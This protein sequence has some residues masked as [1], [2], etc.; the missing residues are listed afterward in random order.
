MKDYYGREFNKNDIKN[1][2]DIGLIDPKSLDAF[3]DEEIR[4]SV[5]LIKDPHNGDRLFLLAELRQILKANHYCRLEDPL[6]RK[7]ILDQVPDFK[8]AIELEEQA[9]HYNAYILDKHPHFIPLLATY[10]KE[11]LHKDDAEAFLDTKKDEIRANHSE[12]LA[13]FYG[14][15]A[16]F[17]EQEKNDFF[18]LIITN[19]R[20]FV[21]GQIWNLPAKWEIDENNADWQEEQAYHYLTEKGLYTP[22]PHRNVLVADLITDPESACLHSWGLDI[23]HLLLEYHM[24][25][26]LPFTLFTLEENESGF[27]MEKTLRERL[28]PAVTLNPEQGLAA[29]RKAIDAACDP[30]VLKL[31]QACTKYMDH[32]VGKLGI[33]Y[34]YPQEIDNADPILLKKYHAVHEMYSSLQQRY[35]GQTDEQ[36]IAAFK[37]LY[38]DPERQATIAEHRDNMGIR[39]LNVL[40]SIL[41]V[42]IKNAVTYYLTEGYSG[43]WNSRG[44]HFNQSLETILED[45]PKTP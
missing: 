5:V 25:K 27:Y 16:N 21:H 15:I 42:G 2:D 8:A 10:V 13:K 28:E 44:D 6:T 33:S 7:D 3:S 29:Y 4:R 41:S 40:F 9:A 36:C 35:A 20:S 23:F 14:Q 30:M 26:N 45:K 31:E 1:K 11:I 17:S 19:R 22:F 37:I 32:L 39:L 43:F 34:P 24:G 18:S 12:E 38:E